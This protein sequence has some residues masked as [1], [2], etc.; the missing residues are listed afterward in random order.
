MT[1]GYPYTQLYQRLVDSS[2]IGATGDSTS[3]C[4]SRTH[5]R[6]RVET[7]RQEKY[8]FSSTENHLSGRGVGFDH[9]AGTHVPCLYRVDPHISQESERRPVTH[10][11]AVSE[12][13]GSD[14]SCVQRDTYWPA[15]HETPTVVAQNQGILPGGKPTSHDQGDVAMPT[16]L[17]HVETTFGSCLR[18]RC[19]ELLVAA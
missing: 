11:Q 5:E 12:T 3:R 8:A 1:P 2:S 17:T 15:V 7:E 19:W 9:D 6:A 13:A 16:C 10:C 18:A 14:G 4:R